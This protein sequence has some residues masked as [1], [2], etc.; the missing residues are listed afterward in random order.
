MASR[1]CLFSFSEISRT[2]REKKRPWDLRFA[3]LV[4]CALC[5]ASKCI[6]PCV[7]VTASMHIG[8]LY[9]LQGKGRGQACLYN[10]TGI[11][12]HS[13]HLSARTG[14]LVQPQNTIQHHLY[15]RA[16]PNTVWHST[17]FLIQH[18]MSLWSDLNFTHTY[19]I[20]RADYCLFQYCT[21]TRH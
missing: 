11:R 21:A 1:P 7:D 4:L 10:S 9:I 20:L 2:N 6:F 17:Q 18:C 15:T 19:S 8:I 14:F 3:L 16:Y 5:E 13:D 12:Y